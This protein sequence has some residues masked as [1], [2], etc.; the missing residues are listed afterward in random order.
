MNQTP[1]L[2]QRRRVVVALLIACVAGGAVTEARILENDVLNIQVSRSQNLLELRMGDDVIQSYP[3][4][5]GTKK[6][7]TPRGTFKIRKIV[8]N[9]GWVPPP[10]KWARGKT[11]KQ[12]GDPDNPMKRVK[13]FFKEP[14]FFIHGTSE[15]D[16]LGEPASHGCIRMHPDDAEI[17][18]K[19]VMEHGG[20]PRPESW[21]RRMFRSRKTKVVYL[22]SPI[23][24]TVR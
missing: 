14:D 3:V 13:M 2:T 8:W 21:F 4:S 19:Y 9:P 5:V 1:A 24:M 16:L 23:T 15:K 22:E 6:Y 17:L 7:P 20:N 11:A 12:P 10:S 18:A